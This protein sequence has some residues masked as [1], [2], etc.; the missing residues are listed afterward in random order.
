[1]IKKKYKRCIGL[2]L[3]ILI[4]VATMPTQS[5]LAN[6]DMN[7][8]SSTNITKEEAKKWAKSKGA[9]NTFINLADLYWKL[10]SDHG[11]INP[12]IAYVQAGIET[13]FGQFGGV[14]NES[15]FNPCGMKNPTGGDDID[16]NAHYRF[17]NWEEGVKAHLDHLALYAGASGYPRINTFDPRHFSYLLGTVKNVNGLSGKWATDLKYGEKILKNYK[18]ILAMSKKPSKMWVSNPINDQHVS[19]DLKIKGW[20]LDSSGVNNIKAYINGTLVG[21]FKIG[22]ASP[23]VNNLYPGYPDSKNAY[24]EGEIPYSKIPNGTSKIIFEV[25]GQ[26]G[27]KQRQEISVKKGKK[28]SK[29]WVSNPINDQHVSSDLKIKGW[30]L[31]S[32]G[33]SDI[34]AYV[35]GMLVGNFK[36]GIASPDVNN[37]YPGYPDSK[38][39]YFEGVI[40]YSKI[41]N[42]T[43]KIIFEVL[44]EDGSKQRQEISVKKGKKPSKMWVS[45]PTNNQYINK[46]I[47]VKGWGLDDSGVS[48]IKAYINATL[49]GDF[50]IGIASPDVNNLHPGY[51]NSGNAYFEGVIP[52]SKIPSGVSKITFIMTGKDNQKTEFEV[53]VRS[54]DVVDLNFDFDFGLEGPSPNNPNKIILHHAAGNATAASVHKFHKFTNKWAGIGYHFYI[55]KDGTIYKGREENWRGAHAADIPS[56]P[57]YNDG[58]PLNDTNATSIGIAV[59]GNYH[60][61]TNIPVDKAMPKAQEDAVVKVGQYLIEKYGVM[62]ILKHGAPTIGHTSCPGNYYPFDRIKARVL[63]KYIYGVYNT[64][65]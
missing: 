64:D 5:V 35:N 56:T 58:N 59:Q 31:D 26:D 23:D 3:S 40:P 16:P 51:P 25:L 39:A 13:G 10:Y 65:L 6:N 19:S 38:N 22:I 41:P 52:Y 2:I 43:S 54:L 47:S 24:F 7:I 21:N 18:E 20:A 62:Q 29:M 33:V 32:S 37:L 1:M 12:G 42:G 28:P 50:K 49:V 36:I 34:K 57:G 45:N 46:D 63:S 27:S 4:M 53:I 60:P 30:A 11:A 17:N 9:T 15:Y 8:I 44:G 55:H 48:D 61:E 14:L